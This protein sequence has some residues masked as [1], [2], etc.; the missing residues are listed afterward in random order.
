[1]ATPAY[2]EGDRISIYIGTGFT[3][4]GSLACIEFSVLILLWKLGPTYLGP[5]AYCDLNAAE[6]NELSFGQILAMFSLFAPILSALDAY[7]GMYAFH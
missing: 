6:E 1:M 5:K 7:N 4:L 3:I 2:V